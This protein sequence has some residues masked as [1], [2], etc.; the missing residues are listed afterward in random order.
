MELEKNTFYNSLKASDYSAD[1]YLDGLT[2]THK[3]YREVFKEWEDRDGVCFLIDPPYL[4][5]QSCTY[6]NYW[7]LR[8]YL[9]V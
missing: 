4:S 3:D 6:S 1:G 9:D 7:R 2:V 8:D 5:T